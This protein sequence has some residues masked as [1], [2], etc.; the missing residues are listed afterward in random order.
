MSSEPKTTKTPGASSGTAKSTKRRRTNLG[1]SRRTSKKTAATT[2]SGRTEEAAAQETNEAGDAT[3]AQD[4]DTTSK[5]KHDDGDS[6][7]DMIDDKEN[8]TA[9]SSS[10]PPSV[11]ELVDAQ[12][13]SK[14]VK[15]DCPKG[16]SASHAYVTFIWDPLRPRGGIDDPF[17]LDALSPRKAHVV[18]SSR[19]KLVDTCKNIRSQFSDW[20]SVICIPVWVL[21]RPSIVSVDTSGKGAPPITVFD[22]KK[23]ALSGVK[24]QLKTMQSTF[25]YAAESSSYPTL[26]VYAQSEN[27]ANKMIRAYTSIPYKK[28][29]TYDGAENASLNAPCSII[30]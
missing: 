26:Y 22:V 13:L 4:D 1:K 21:Q 25:V 19:K 14:P 11:F 9:T 30:E 7:T 20:D 2:D 18:Y 29:A 15:H 24:K 23:G 3:A 28:I 12:S 8:D 16:V 17:I 10:E 27:D 5:E 6:R